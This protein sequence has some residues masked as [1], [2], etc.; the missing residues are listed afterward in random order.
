MK[1][2]P[3][4][5]LWIILLV[6]AFVIAGL[7]H[8]TIFAGKSLREA[9]RPYVSLNRCFLTAYI[10]HHIPHTQV[11]GSLVDCLVKA[12]SSGNPKA[13]GK[14]GEIG[15]LQFMPS[16]FQHFCVEKYNYRDDIW[17]PEIQRKCCAEML[18][19]GLINHWSTKDLCM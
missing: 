15:I 1:D 12:E 7:G 3:P 19:E 13:V 14:A 10:P 9:D 2:K 5:W 11:L 4:N 8:T 18:E 16:T 17:S 6:I